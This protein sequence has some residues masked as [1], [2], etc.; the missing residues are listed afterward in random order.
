MSTFK[1]FDELPLA[2]RQL[3]GVEC[4][5]WLNRLGPLLKLAGEPSIWGANTQ[6]GH[7]TQLL[8]HVH[9]KI[10]VAGAEAEKAASAVL[11]NR[12]KI[13]L[14]YWEWL[15]KHG[16]VTSF[17]TFVNEFDY[18]A[19]DCK[20]VYEGV[21]LPCFEIFKQINNCHYSAPQAQIGRTSA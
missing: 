10:V 14:A 7:L 12:L 13:T 8:I 9:Q 16:R 6:L 5:Y 4:V 21:V 18:Q 20:Q 15:E 19:E 17:S 3:S 2:S 1:T 11:G